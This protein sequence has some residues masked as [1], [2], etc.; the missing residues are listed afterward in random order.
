[1]DRTVHGR[2]LFGNFGPIIN[3]A[4]PRSVSLPSAPTAAHIAETTGPVFEIAETQS[5]C[6]VQARNPRGR[7]RPLNQPLSTAQPYGHILLARNANFFNEHGDGMSYWMLAE[8]RPASVRGYHQAVTFLH[9]AQHAIDHWSL[10]ELRQRLART[11]SS[12]LMADLL[13]ASDDD[14]NSEENDGMVVDDGMSH[15]TSSVFLIIFEM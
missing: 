15:V 9:R 12:P 11:V 7:I 10:E 8:A 6:I 13:V 1:M 3:G 4:L 2:P 5:H 14:E